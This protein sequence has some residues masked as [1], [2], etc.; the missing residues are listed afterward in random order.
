MATDLNNC[1]DLLLPE[2]PKDSYCESCLLRLPDSNSNATSIRS[3]SQ[4]FYSVSTQY[5][6]VR[7]QLLSMIIKKTFSEETMSYDGSPFMFCDEHRGLNLAVGF[8]LEDVH[9]RGN[10]RR[11]CLILSLEKSDSW[12]E[13]EAFQIL[14]DN[15]QFI[16]ESFAKL[17]NHVKIMSREQLNRRQTDFAQIMGGTYLRENKQKLPVSLA[18]I[19]GDE[20]IFLRIHKW[21]TFIL[22]KIKSAGTETLDSDGVKDIVEN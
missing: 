11:Y 3:V 16:I 13:N 2:Y 5:S 21:N 18:D 19:V 1:R 8:R 15:W 7:Y 22:A 9:A 14:S 17:I 12:G 6:S 20:L 10:E 4:N